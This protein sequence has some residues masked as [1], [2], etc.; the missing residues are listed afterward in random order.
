IVGGVDNPMYS[1]SYV[2]QKVRK[3]P[4]ERVVGMAGVLDSARLQ[5]FI[6]A[7]LKVSADSVQTMVLGGH[8]DQMVPLIRCTTVAGV[9][10]SEW[11]PKERMDALVQR[12]QEGG[13]EVVALLKTGT[14]Y[15][16]PSASIV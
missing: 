1:V 16:A 9:P 13:A 3:F 15:Y 8:G 11:L 10:L 5:S 4:R 7:E 14:G 2:A 12:T 6:A